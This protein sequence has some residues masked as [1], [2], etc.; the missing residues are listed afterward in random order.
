[1]A[2]ARACLSNA[3]RS[4]SFP[5]LHAGGAA[6]LGVV[7]AAPSFPY[8]SSVDAAA[9][10]SRE[11]ISDQVAVTRAPSPARGRRSRRL[12]WKNPWDLIPF[13]LNDG[14]G[15]ALLQVS[16]NLNGLLERLSPSRLLGRL[17]E[18]DKCYKLRYEVPG[19][20]KEDL[21]VTVEDGM[22]VIIGESEDEDEDAVDESSSSTTEDEGQGGWH[23]RRYGY[24]NATLLLPE[25]A[26]AD[27]ITAE[28]R[29]G[30]LRIYIPRSEEKKSTAREIEIK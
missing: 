29:D 26:K 4:R 11:D 13:H 18:D 9:D 15:N 30:I 7:A 5:L 6:R 16:E 8:S 24:I 17:K 2:L 21:R 1:M 3:L 28:L 27:E 19:L 20:R 25:D 14:L 12:T 10:S 23:L 22:L